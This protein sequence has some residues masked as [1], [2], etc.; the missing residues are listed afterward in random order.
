MS[1]YFIRIKFHKKK[2][3][4]TVAAAALALAVGACSSSSDDDET[5]SAAPPPA[6][7]GG[8]PE[9]PAPDPVLTELEIV[10]AAA[11]QAAKDAGDAAT[12]AK[13]ASDAALVA[14]ESRAVIQTGDLQEEGNSGML[15]HAAYT[16]AKAAAGA[17]TAAQEASDLAAEATDVQAATRA[18]VMAETAKDNAETAQGMAKAQR[19]A[20]VLAAANEVKIVDK[21]KSVGDTSITV[22]VDDTRTVT[23]NGATTRTGKEAGIVIMSKVVAGRMAKD[24]VVAAPND[25]PPVLAAAAITP[26][27]GV[28]AGRPITIGFVYDSADDSARVALVHSYIGSTTVTAYFNDGNTITFDGDTYDSDN[29]DATP[30]LPVKAATGTYYLA[31]ALD[32]TGLIEVETTE[33]TSLYYY[34]TDVDGVTTKKFLHRTMTSTDEVT[35]VVTYIYQP[36]NT[37]AGVAL[38]EATE[39]AHHHYCIWADLKEATKKGDNPISE[40]GVG[41]VAGLSEMT[42]DDMPNHG[43]A[44]Y[45]GG[46]IA[47]VQAAD[48]DGNGGITMQTG[49]SEIVADFE[50]GD[51][52]ITLTDLATLEGTIIDGNTFSGS[53]APTIA[54]A[55]ADIENGGLDVAGK[56]TGSLSGAFFGPKAKEAGGVFDYSSED[57][58]DGA[59]R[60]AFGGV[61]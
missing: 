59:F 60:G 54:A 52:D 15:A 17:A 8:D 16:Q 7:P 43:G 4:T 50:M 28:T 26:K 6:A 30:A 12:L 41:F 55:A 51:V 14:R 25:N 19:D 27:P 42:S 40:L 13:M 2:L 39:Y 5:L 36:V 1:I 38:P 31:T 11:V 22:G 23:I 34:E 37:A 10:Q 61:R 47:H 56:F 53:K 45:K 29:D 46:W 58:E 3:I 35:K 57:N 49:D 32:E 9:T 48:P 20:A 33:G 44:T 21:T 18:L 24:A